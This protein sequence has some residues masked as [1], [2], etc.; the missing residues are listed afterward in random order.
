MNKIFLVSLF[1]VSLWAE[2]IDGI[3]VVVKDE[4]ITL[5]DVKEEMALSHVDAKQASD[6]L[7]R[8]KLEASEIKE[9]KISITSSEVYEDIKKTA[10]ANNMSVSQFYDAVRESNGLSSSQLKEKI[11]EKLL[12][13]QLYSSIAY[14]NLS[15]PNDD[16][17]AEYY[18][19]H[20]DSF[21]HP[22]S[23][24]V[25]IYDSQDQSRLEEKIHNIMFYAPDITTNEQTLPY[26]RISPELASLLEKTPVN[27]F[28]PVVP[29]GKGGFMSLYVKEVAQQKD[30]SI[31]NVKSQIVNMIMAQKREQVL[32]D[33]FARLKDNSEIKILRL[34]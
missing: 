4:A 6:I 31:E 18:K 22:S 34:P 21:S 19:L 1:V 11:K 25:I 24:D 16:E 8:K 3:A 30:T 33:Y 29:N 7:I 14:S 10:A 2:L 20:K 12:S 32:S 13:Q 23:F 15:E 9:R 5:L 17:I 28:T 27:N 26:D